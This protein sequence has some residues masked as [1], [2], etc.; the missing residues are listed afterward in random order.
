MAAIGC[1]TAAA[2][3]AQP[4]APRE[5]E[6]ATDPIR[7]WWKTDRT[8]IRVGE[9]FS[10]VLTCA[11]I[12][13]TGITVVPVVNQLEPG[14]ISLTPFEAIAGVRREDVV[15]PPWRYLQYEYTMRLLSEGFFGQD[16]NIPSLTVTYSLRSAGAG[17]EGRDQTYLL[18]PLPMRVE[19]LV[20]R[21]A[22]DIRDASTLTFGDVEDRRF[23]STL[24]LVA[25][26]IAFAFAAVLAGLAVV[27]A[28]G[29]VRAR[30][31]QAV[32]PLPAP[33]LLAGCLREL[34]RARADA[35]HAGW[36]PELRS[37]AMAALR[38]AAA[39]ALGRPV[40]QQF[41][42]NGT[43]ERPGQLSVR[44][45]VVRR[46]RA[47]VSAAMTPLAI[48]GRL[49][50]ADLRGAQ[51]RVNVEQIADALRVFGAATY[52]RTGEADA[53]T[54]NSAVDHATAAIRRLRVSSLWPMRTAQAVERSI[55]GA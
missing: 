20:P 54:L 50:S 4:R 55:L 49:Q 37:R 24:A 51:A 45:G 41:V 38:V 23:T 36:T 43:P 30:D 12:E 47:L 39:L 32:R 22:T 18:P 9:P 7:C 31:P 6:V 53:M 16:V 48:A 21:A 10:L 17:S 25:A 28:A 14:A 8:A 3:V 40:A 29:R 27:R 13:T 5:G 19:S 1:V 11:T 46:R 15:V 42:E 2:A 35:A 44:T 52:G 33:S 26:W 34:N